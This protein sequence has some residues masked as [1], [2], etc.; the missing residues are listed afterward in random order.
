MKISPTHS[1]FKVSDKII[2]SGSFLVIRVNSNLWMSMRENEETH[3]LHKLKLK[4]DRRRDKKERKSG[5]ALETA[6][7]V[8]MDLHTKTEKS[9]VPRSLFTDLYARHT[10]AQFFSGTNITYSCSYDMR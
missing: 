5:K 7:A 9:A 6:A 3:R 4:N 2:V 10:V 8:E 1:Y